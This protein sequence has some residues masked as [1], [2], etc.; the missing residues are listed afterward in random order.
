MELWYEL[1]VVGCAGRDLEDGTS[2]GLWLRLWCYVRVW[3]DH[4][5]R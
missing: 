1:D 2:I 5:K 3:L 4:K